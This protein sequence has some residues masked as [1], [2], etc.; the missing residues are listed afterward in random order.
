MVNTI[1][2]PSGLTK[3]VNKTTI[4]TN[5]NGQYDFHQDRQK[6]SIKLPSGLTKMVNK[7]TIKT[8]KNGQ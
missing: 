2:L 1:R 8:D 7:T 4:K 6:W 5:K 3:M